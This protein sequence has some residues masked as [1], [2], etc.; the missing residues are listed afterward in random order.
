MH[1]KLV[2]KL[3]EFVYDLVFRGSDNF[4][5]FDMEGPLVLTKEGIEIKL[6]KKYE[7]QELTGQTGTF[8]NLLYQG[9]GSID[10]CEG[11]WTYVGHEREDKYNGTWKMVT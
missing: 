3:S 9:R 7:N 5:C 6:L 10:L 1:I 8:Q 11:T 2:F 4:G